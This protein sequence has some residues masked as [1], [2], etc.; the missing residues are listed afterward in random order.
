MYNDYSIQWNGV[1]ILHKL[2][3]TNINNV[4]KIA[5]IGHLSK[6]IY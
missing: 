2:N 4:L 6:F 3:C 5:T 1:M